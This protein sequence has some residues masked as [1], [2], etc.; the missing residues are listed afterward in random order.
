MRLVLLFYLFATAVLANNLTDYSENKL[1]DHILR[2]Q[3]YSATNPSNLYIGLFTT[4]CGDAGLGTEV[5]GGGYARA[6]V[7]RDLY[8]W[9]STQNV[10]DV[11]SSG[12]T[13]SI[14]NTYP[15]QFPLATADWGVV[16]YWGLFDAYTSGNLILCASLN[17]RR[18]IVVG[19]TPAF[20]VGALTIKID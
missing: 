1:L 14:S 12:T 9:K 8:S 11:L 10:D 20:G 19:T 18:N 16:S 5:L 3:E 7:T 13:G 6:G 15:I 4:P 17:T 2:G